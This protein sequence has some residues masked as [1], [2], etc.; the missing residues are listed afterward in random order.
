MS[1]NDISRCGFVAVIG[2][3]N[4]GKSTLLNALVGSKVAIVTPKVQTTRHRIRG[5]CNVGRAQIV[6]TDT[7]GI[8]A[9]E[10]PFE[11]A[12]VDA[13][14]AGVA[15]ADATLM[16]IDANAGF[17]SVVR[18]ILERLQTLRPKHLYVALNKVDETEKPKLLE[19]AVQLDSYGIFSSIFM[20]S[21]LKKDGLEDVKKTLAEVLPEGPHLYPDEEYTDQSVRLL[22]SEITR[23]K[24][25]MRLHQEL[26][27]SLHVE[28][29]SWEEQPDGQVHVRQVI[30]AQ[31]ESQKKIIIGKGGEMLKEIGSA[32][33]REMN[34]LLDRRVHLTLF[35]KV[36]EDW[37]TDAESYRYFGLEKK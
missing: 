29:E 2:A 33:R 18:D 8:F 11:K 36:R 13:A 10:Q 26:P 20:I 3:P 34:R 9:A 31:R 22:A 30:F 5:I 32:A 35:V 16:V 19:L 27:Y 1:K 4:A 7:P 25:F 21:A 6:F 23:E 28:T 12:M 24:L 37:K 14:W 17:Y 15:D